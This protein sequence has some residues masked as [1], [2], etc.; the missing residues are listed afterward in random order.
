MNRV[1]PIVD[2]LNVAMAA[3]IALSWLAHRTKSK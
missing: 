3:G 2:S 1:D